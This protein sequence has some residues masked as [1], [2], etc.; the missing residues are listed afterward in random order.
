MEQ[1]ILQLE[2]RVALLQE[3]KRQV[4]KE[5]FRFPLDFATQEVMKKTFLTATGRTFGTGSVILTDLIGIG[6]GLGTNS[7]QLRKNAIGTFPLYQFTVNAGTNVFTSSGG[8]QNGDILN[9]ATSN[10][11]PDPLSEVSDYYVINASNTTFKV[12]L[13]EGGSEVDIT[14]AGSGNHYYAIV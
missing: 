1:E 12:S 2:R 8:L 6:V 11:L 10:T 14:T 9:F 3:Y 13:T 5:R 7:S 4:T